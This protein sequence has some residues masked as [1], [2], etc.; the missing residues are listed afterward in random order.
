MRLQRKIKT[1]K[2]EVKN[3]FNVDAVTGSYPLLETAEDTATDIN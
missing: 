1:V 3:K 2:E